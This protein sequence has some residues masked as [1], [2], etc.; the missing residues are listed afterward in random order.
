MTVYGAKVSQQ[1]FDVRTAADR[2]LTYSSEWPL[3]KIAFQGTVTIPDATQDV[4][5]V[6]HG[7]GYVPAFWAFDTGTYVAPFSGTKLCYPGTSQFIVANGTALQWRG[8]SRGAG[9]GAITLRYMLFR[10]DLSQAFT[11][12]IIETAADSELTNQDY[13]ILVSKPGYSVYDPDFRNFTIRSDCRSP[14]IHKTGTG[15]FGVGGGNV[16]VTHDLTYEP[17]YYFWAKIASFGDDFWQMVATADDSY[18]EATSTTIKLALPYES[19]YSYMVFKD[20]MLL[21]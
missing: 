20:P 10:Q 9:A 12:Q 15:S 4:T 3:L 1:G 13:G 18:S 19:Q 14:M 17:M 11:A 5:I 16:T 8:A 2:Q 21:N 6:T 7:L